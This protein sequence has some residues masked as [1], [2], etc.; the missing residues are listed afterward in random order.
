MIIRTHSA[1]IARVHTIFVS[2]AFDSSLGYT[3]SLRRRFTERQH[4]ELVRTELSVT[5]HSTLPLPPD[6]NY[7]TRISDFFLRPDELQFSSNYPLH[8]GTAR[9]CKAN[10][11]PSI[12]IPTPGSVAPRATLLQFFGLPSRYPELDSLQM[13]SSGTA[14]EYELAVNPNYSRKCRMFIFESQQSSATSQRSSKHQVVAGEVCPAAP[15]DNEGVDRPSGIDVQVEEKKD[16][17]TK[18]LP[19]SG[20][21]VT[22][23]CTLSSVGSPLTVR[24]R[25]S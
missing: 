23:V 2:G 18:N 5:S 7:S 8:Q 19:D 14:A 25:Y 12:A 4:L 10:I 1:S 13:H 20:P 24:Y 3:P 16:K 21:R 9:V 15:I 6:D 17:Y 11:S 22:T